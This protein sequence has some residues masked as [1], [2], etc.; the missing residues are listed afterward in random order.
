MGF[1]TGTRELFLARD[2]C[3]ILHGGQGDQGKDIVSDK[4]EVGG[5]KNDVKTSTHHEVS[6]EDA[7]LVRNHSFRLPVQLLRLIRP[8]RHSL[9]QDNI[10]IELPEPFHD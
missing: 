9:A 6:F 2:L 10:H 1:L 3:R 7:P 4:S 5:G 8:F